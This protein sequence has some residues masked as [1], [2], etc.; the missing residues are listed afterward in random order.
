MAWGY[1]TIENHEKYL[2]S[3]KPFP[4]FATAA[5]SR[6][7]SPWLEPGIEQLVMRYRP[8]LIALFASTIIGVLGSIFTTR[9]SAYILLCIGFVL[10][11][12]IAWTAWLMISLVVPTIIIAVL[13]VINLNHKRPR[14][15]MLTCYLT[16]H[17]IIF[18]V[19]GFF[20]FSDYW[21]IF[22]D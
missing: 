8:W 9:W 20:Y 15:L 4:G 1:F 18:I 10:S 7:E 6:N 21:D 5:E 11:P 3:S 16:L 17:Y 13:L 14:D 12:L 2:W 19:V 22:G